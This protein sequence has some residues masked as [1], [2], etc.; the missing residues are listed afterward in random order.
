[1][2]VESLLRGFLRAVMAEQE[3]AP[4]EKLVIQA[5]EVASEMQRRGTPLV[6]LELWLRDHHAAD[7]AAVCGELQRAIDSQAR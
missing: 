2:I 4:D 7:A 1:M 5:R 3:T 6:M